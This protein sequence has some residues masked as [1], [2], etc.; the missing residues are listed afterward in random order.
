MNAEVAVESINY[1]KEYQ[2]LISSG[3]TLFICFI[4]LFANSIIS[5][6]QNV[7]AISQEAHTLRLVISEDLNYIKEI[8]KNEL[9]KDEKDNSKVYYMQI[10]TGIYRGCISKLGLLSKDEIKMLINTYNAF[11]IHNTALRLYKIK[12]SELENM[13]TN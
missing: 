7:R 6:A 4:T 11:E 1:W 3:V 8:L 12:S 9:K 2:V 13:V 5:R 10:N